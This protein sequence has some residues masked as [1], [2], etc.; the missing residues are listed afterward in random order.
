MKYEVWPSFRP[1]LRSCLLILLTVL[2]S[3][4]ATVA[5]AQRFSRELNVD[6]WI[7]QAGYV[8]G[9]GKTV[10]TNIVNSE[11]NRIAN[12]PELQHLIKEW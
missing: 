3:L 12:D 7:N 2:L 1:E 6:L 4:T 9:A 5:H 10:V 11:L 8:P